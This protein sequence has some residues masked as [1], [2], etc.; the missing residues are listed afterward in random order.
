M[1]CSGAFVS[2]TT[3]GAGSTGAVA[4]TGA[5]LET[6]VC[7]ATGWAAAYSACCLAI[8]FCSTNHQPSKTTQSETTM[9]P[10]LSMKCYECAIFKKFPLSAFRFWERGRV[11]RRSTD[12]NGKCARRPAPFL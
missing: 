6:V 9:I 1:V 3:A 10:V 7:A 5:A 2:N 8:L 12:D 4:V 11:R